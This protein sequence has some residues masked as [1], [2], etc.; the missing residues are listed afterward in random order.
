MAGGISFI[1][2]KVRGQRTNDTTLKVKQALTERF[3][4][5]T[6]NVFEPFCRAYIPKFFN[7][8]PTIDSLEVFNQLFAHRMEAPLNLMLALEMMKYLKFMNGKSSIGSNLHHSYEQY[9]LSVCISVEMELRNPSFDGFGSYSSY[10]LLNHSTDSFFHP[11]VTEAKTVMLNAACFSSFDPS[12]GLVPIPNFKQG[13]KQVHWEGWFTYFFHCVEEVSNQ[14]MSLPIMF[15][16]GLKRDDMVAFFKTFDY[17]TNQKLI[18]QPMLLLFAVLN[19]LN[20]K[21]TPPNSDPDQIHF[22]PFM[23]WKLHTTW[24]L[25][26]NPLFVGTLQTIIFYQAFKCP[27][28][29]ARAYQ[30]MLKDPMRTTLMARIGNDL[31]W[32]DCENSIYAKQAMHMCQV[33]IPY[34]YAYECSYIILIIGLHDRFFHIHST[35]LLYLSQLYFCQD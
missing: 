8:S 33:C 23:A 14:K 10:P 13:K 15:D 31:K 2:P 12:D 11:Y 3:G 16:K 1:I 25:H 32:F 27:I 26:I 34:Y 7:E 18:R 6:A 9:A 19:L 22:A 30:D 4:T 20:M 24:M 17:R 35:Y 29:S 21:H 28:T 5:D